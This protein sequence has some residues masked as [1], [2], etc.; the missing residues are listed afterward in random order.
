MF[1]SCATRGSA[2]DSVCGTAA[3]RVGLPGISSGDEV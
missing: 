3:L 1:F 2:D